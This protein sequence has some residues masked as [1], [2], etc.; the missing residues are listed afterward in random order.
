[1]HYII[2]IHEL[3]NTSH[4]VRWTSFLSADVECFHLVLQL[5][6]DS[7]YCLI[8]SMYPITWR[9]SVEAD[10]F[11]WD[12]HATRTSSENPFFGRG[13]WKARSERSRDAVQLGRGP[14]RRNIRCAKWGPAASAR[15]EKSTEL[16]SR[17]KGNVLGW[18]ESSRGGNCRP[19]R[20]IGPGRVSRFCRGPPRSFD[21]N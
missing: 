19:T 16:A 9:T 12:S 13:G 2:A 5:H 10:N 7:I 15:F 14:F 4:D 6:Y 1:M 21:G 3:E 17:E 11:S 20:P 18:H 8:Y